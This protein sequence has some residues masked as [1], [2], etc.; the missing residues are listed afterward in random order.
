MRFLLEVLFWYFNTYLDI[1]QN[2]VVPTLVC[3][4]FVTYF[5]TMKM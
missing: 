5:L 1:E 2:H 4:T 3:I